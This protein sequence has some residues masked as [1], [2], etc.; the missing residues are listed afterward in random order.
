MAGFMAGFG[1][2]LSNLIEEDRK[3]YRESA[4]KRRDYLQT[5]GTKAV[6]DREEKANAAL[7][8]VNSLI[9]SGIPKDDVRYV[10]DTSGVQG[11]AE[12]QATIKSR[13]DLSA[14]DR[15]S[16]VQK[17]KDYVADNPDEDINTVIKRAY[18]LY[19]SSEKP[20][21]RERNLLSS[22][23]GLDA[24]MMED[25]VL[26]DLY[27]NGMTGRDI[28]RI[29][30][31]SGPKPGAPLSLDLPA[32]PPSPQDRA[33]AAKT[34]VAQFESSIDGRINSAIRANDPALR[35]KLEDLKA[36]GVEG[37]ADYAMEYDTGLLDFA[38]EIE[39][40]QPGVITRN[41]I[42]LGTFPSA[43]NSYIG[44]AQDDAKVATAM[45]R[46]AVATTPTV[47]TRTAPTSTTTKAHTFETTSEFT[48]AV[49][50][51]TVQPGDTVSIA[52]REGGKVQMYQPLEGNA[53]GF[54]ERDD[55]PLPA[56]VT[57]LLD[58]KDGKI[59]DYEDLYDNL[60]ALPEDQRS[61]YAKEYQKL[62]EVPAL[63]EIVAD[64]AEEVPG[65]TDKITGKAVGGAMW[66]LGAFTQGVAEVGNFLTGNTAKATRLSLRSKDYREAA[67]D[68][69]ADGIVASIEA[70]AD[71]READLVEAAEAVTPERI[72]Q[73]KK[74]LIESAALDATVEEL[75]AR[76]S[77]ILENDRQF[78][79]DERSFPQPLGG[80][81]VQPKPE[82]TDRIRTGDDVSSFQE[83]TEAAAIR[84]AEREA[85]MA[86][87]DRIEEADQQ[88]SAD[89]A[90][91]PPEGLMSSRR[92]KVKPIRLGQPEFMDLIE[93]LHGPESS[94]VSTWREKTSSP[95]AEL[96]VSDVTRLIK[97]TQALPRT[98]SRS[99][100]L[101]SLYDL[102]DAMNNRK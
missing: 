37:I 16:L 17:A 91:F 81:M 72:A 51:G 7:G 20:V 24:R 42:N 35:D 23:L 76:E 75:I 100:L 40:Q 28:Y 8:V 11:I 84:N 53:P 63:T 4:A 77:R 74:E 46:E 69:M 49:E 48:A 96:K 2:T 73:I 59:E 71:R 85:R 97:E 22:V 13:S 66:A 10:L 19:K 3:Y 6:V 25:D 15:Q 30:G 89:E 90:S 38:Y 41:S 65:L 68:V 32:K 60:M 45:D 9:S 29:M 94:V 80:L 57:S 102:R 18:G 54:R 67:K 82:P 50:E 88:F 86:R 14:E 93:T 43:F 33:A 52:N 83:R 12:L 47:G 55:I 92:P 5:Y 21:E 58:G 1:T 95:D 39:Q 78:L 62:Q 27:V 26:D 56:A 31:S 98:K 101:E 44:D 36:R 79:A 87:E 34:L 70:M 61:A 64:I 99:T